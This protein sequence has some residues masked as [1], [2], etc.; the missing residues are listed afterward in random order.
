MIIVMVLYRIC[1][2]V[3]ILAFTEAKESKIGLKNSFSN[4]I[5]YL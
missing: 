2:P 5:L 3:Q 4:S 1:N